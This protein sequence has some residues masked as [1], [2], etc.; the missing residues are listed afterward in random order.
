MKFNKL[1]PELAVSDLKKSL[2]FYVDT[3]GFKVEYERP[4][5][6]FVFLS[7]QGSQIMLEEIRNDDSPWFT[8]P[9]EKP[10]G[11]GIHFQ[12]S[13][14]KIQPLLETLKEK[15]Y[16]VKAEPKEYWYR[17]KGQLVGFK[18]FLVLDPDGYLLMFN[19]D[20]GSKPVI[21]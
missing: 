20:L 1:I 6:N 17:V 10:F 14:D 8:G 9:L 15:N 19:E 12:I 18:G 5:N 13:V 4:E 3:L 11:R 16:P 7:L 2:E 21:E